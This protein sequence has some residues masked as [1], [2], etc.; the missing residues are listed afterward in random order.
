MTDSRAKAPAAG[1]HEQRMQ[2]RISGEIDRRLSPWRA[3][4]GID[5]RAYEHH[6]TRVLLLC[7]RLHLRTDPASNSPPSRRSEYLTAAVFHDLGI[8]TARTFDYLAPSVEL[9]RTWLTS[10]GDQ[11]LEP[12]VTDMIEQHHKIRGADAPT[13][14][15]EI[16]RRADTI[17]LT[18]GLRRFGVPLH[19]YRSL[20]RRYPVAGFH[21]RLVAFAWKHLQTNPTSPLPMLKW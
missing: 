10:E 4:L 3:Q 5:Y 1:R 15:V 9:A 6:V 19:E 16:F 21:R 14:P 18:L 12:L 20:T 8:W 11:R 7:D 13:S 17:D 2:N